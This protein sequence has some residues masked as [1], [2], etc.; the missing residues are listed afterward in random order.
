MA[1]SPGRVAGYLWRPE[2][3]SAPAR[4]HRPFRTTLETVAHAQPT[5]SETLPALGRDGREIIRLCYISR[6]GPRA[7]LRHRLGRVSA[8]RFRSDNQDGWNYVAKINRCT[9]TVM[10]DGV[11]KVV[12]YSKMSPE[13][14]AAASAKATG[15]AARISAAA[16]RLAARD[17]ALEETVANF[18]EKVA[19]RPL[20]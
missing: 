12:E 1:T 9:F 15:L 20:A 11:R 8:E 18:I 10:N 19:R 2:I 17:P 5:S 3:I 7:R 16:G 13:Q 6:D 4:D 14:R